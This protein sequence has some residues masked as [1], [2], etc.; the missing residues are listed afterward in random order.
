M[1]MQNLPR[2]WFFKYILN[3]WLSEWKQFDWF[4][5]FVWKSP[6]ENPINIESFLF[7]EILSSNSNFFSKIALGDRNHMEIGKKALKQNFTF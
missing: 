4:W 5:N 3:L 2:D 7:F 1:Q 6:T